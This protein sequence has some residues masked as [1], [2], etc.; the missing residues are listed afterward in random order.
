MPD[1]L[2]ARVALTLHLFGWFASLFTVVVGATVLAGWLI[3][4]PALVTIH[5]GLAAMSP[6]TAAGF[7]L[8]GLSLASRK[9]GKFP[10]VADATA[11][12]LL[13]LGLIV[14]ASHIAFGGDRLNPLLGIRIATPEGPIEGHT[15]PATAL[16]F[17]LLGFILLSLQQPH[18]LRLKLVTICAGIGT[19]LTSVDLL[20][21]AY[22]VEGLYATAFYRSTALHTATC[23]FLLFLATLLF[24]PTEGLAAII[25]SGRPSGNV[26]RMQLLVTL[27]M[28]ACAGFLLLHA[29]RT[30]ALA[31]SLC[32]ALLVVCTTVPMV[33]RIMADG[34]M[35]DALDM[36]LRA[37]IGNEQKLNNELEARVE[38]RTAE[39]QTAEDAL[40]QAQKMEA[41]G[42]LTGGL[43]HDFNNLLTGIIGSLG[44]MQMRITQGRF[45][46]IERYITTAQLSSKRAASLI[47]RLLAFSRQQTLDPQ[48]TD[49]N[50]LVLNMEEL[51]RRTTGPSIICE[52]ITAPGLWTT[53]VDASQVESALL[54]LVINARDAMPQGGG[55]LI[56]TG[57][58]PHHA[59]PAL[60]LPPSDYAYLAVSDTGGGMSS[61]VIARAF[62]PFF[63]TKPIGQ[64]SGLGLS[65][66]YGFVRQSGGHVRLASQI[67]QGTKLSLYFPRHEGK[68]LAADTDDLKLPALPATQGETVLVVDDEPSV[69]MLVTDMLQELGYTAMEAPDGPAALNIL[70]TGK[71]IDLLVSDLGLPGGL[72][73]RQVAQ[74]ARAYQPHVKV[75]LITGYAESAVLRDGE[76]PDG[77]HALSKPFAMEDLAREIRA[78]LTQEPV[79]ESMT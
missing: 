30:G 68:V 52:L 63:T 19:L 23:L 29:L 17:L 59:A 31:P 62:D 51:L 21:Y 13:A 16:A 53:L 25:T 1:T 14:T 47:H 37:A 3:G 33:V 66:V 73:G 74:E 79:R 43:A 54:N 12:L 20:G 18:R 55:L 48:P 50:L 35:L 46:D 2:D 27:L 69:R 70:R 77:M 5:H 7:I 8:A 49:I 75:L 45:N 41:V 24:D 10:H 57:N 71:R 28:P 60:D 72:N 42:Q 6:L 76:L 22:G 61:E 38:A 11:L 26:T 78:L 40:R 65:M 34:L 4:A 67:G 36:K 9:H 32:M 58:I 56:E 15:G 64:G 44:L 39:L